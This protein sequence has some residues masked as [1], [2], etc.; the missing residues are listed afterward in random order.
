MEYSILGNAAFFAVVFAAHMGWSSLDM[1]SLEQDDDDDDVAVKNSIQEFP[2][3]Q[4]I[5]RRV[6]LSRKWEHQATIHLA[7]HPIYPQLRYLAYLETTV[8]LAPYP[9]IILK[10]MR[11]AIRLTHLMDMTRPMEGVNMIL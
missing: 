4:G 11:E 7:H 3:E 8:W 5:G 6:I 2:N 10:E 1:L 9:M